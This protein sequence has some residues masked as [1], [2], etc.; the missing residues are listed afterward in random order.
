MKT[1]PK[2]ISG[3]VAAL[4]SGVLVTTTAF[5]LDLLDALT[6]FLMAPFLGAVWLLYAAAATW[7]LIHFLLNA[8][9][10]RR[11]AIP[12]AICVVAFTV[13]T[14]FPFTQIW[15]KYNFALKRGARE[16]VV[17]MVEA[18]QLRP[19]V[20]HNPSL[21]RLNPSEGSLSKG[22]NEIVAER[23]ANGTY[24]FFYTFRGILDSYS[25]FLSVPPNGHPSDFG[26]LN[27]AGSTEIVEMAEG[28]YFASH[29]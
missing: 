28:W 3:Y 1:G 16:R 23:H 20:A 6:P 17:A 26:D 10:W 11:S 29:R 12:L 24:V 5:E 15:L 4:A 22:G 14:T 18:G 19:N 7:S 8:R 2:L 9:A 21:I 13:V 25:G 27:E